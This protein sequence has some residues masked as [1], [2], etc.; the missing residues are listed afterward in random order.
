MYAL[1]AHIAPVDENVFIFSI[2]EFDIKAF[3]GDRA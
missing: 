3:V 1:N 2:E